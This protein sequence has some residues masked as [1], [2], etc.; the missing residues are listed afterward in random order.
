MRNLIVFQTVTNSDQEFV[1]EPQKKLR[2]KKNLIHAD[3]LPFDKIKIFPM[4]TSSSE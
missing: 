3:Q 2:N 4:K 1:S